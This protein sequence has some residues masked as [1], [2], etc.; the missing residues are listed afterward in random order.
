MI[1]SIFLVT[2]GSQKE[3]LKTFRVRTI[4]VRFICEANF[5]TLG[6]VK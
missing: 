2:A 5:R 4:Q 1:K 6:K 3:S